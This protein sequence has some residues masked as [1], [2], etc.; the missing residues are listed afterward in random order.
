MKRCTNEI[1]SSNVKKARRITKSHRSF[2]FLSVCYG[3]VAC[4]GCEV[5]CVVVDGQ[6]KNKERPPHDSSEKLKPS[7]SR[8]SKDDDG[9]VATYRLVDLFNI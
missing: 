8:K 6:R 3:F 9:D 4:L 5:M 2:D 7:P 1:I